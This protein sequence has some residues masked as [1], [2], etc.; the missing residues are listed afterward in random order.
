[1]RW[2]SCSN[3]VALCLYDLLLLGFPY[4]LLGRGK[5]NAVER[6]RSNDVMHMVEFAD[7]SNLH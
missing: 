1:M 7:L 4:V 5:W 6:R 3:R 2:L